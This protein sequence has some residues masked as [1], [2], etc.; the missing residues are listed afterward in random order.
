MCLCAWVGLCDTHRQATT[1][2]QRSM[3]WDERVRQEER[4]LAKLVK[5]CKDHVRRKSGTEGGSTASGEPSVRR[6]RHRELAKKV[7]PTSM[8]MCVSVCVCAGG[9]WPA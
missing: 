5:A 2:N 3:W 6:E 8:C 7:L 1:P 9:A 4:A